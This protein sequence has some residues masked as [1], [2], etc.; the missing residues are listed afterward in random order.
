MK[1]NSQSSQYWLPYHHIPQVND[2][3]FTQTY[4]FCWGCEYLYLLDF[5][6]RE[7]KKEPYASHLDF[8]CGDGR[9]LNFMYDERESR[10]IAGIDMDERAVTY[11]EKLSPDTIHFYCDDIRNRYETYDVITSIEVFEHI[12]PALLRELI[13]ALFSRLNDNGR[14]IFTVPSKNL[15]IPNKH[16]QHFDEMS[17]R[18]IFSG[19]MLDDLQYFA[20]KSKKEYV[21]LKIFTN[22]FFLLNYQPLLDYLYKIYGKLFFHAKA[23]NGAHIY[24]C[25]RKPGRNHAG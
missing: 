19:Y 8:G 13:D 17:L 16:Y 2:G 20:V 23:D 15:H 12:P 3:H 5:I 9:L 14:L 18:T 1:K 7:V 6:N 24:A 22:R 10:K 25:C 4:N 11:A 21:F